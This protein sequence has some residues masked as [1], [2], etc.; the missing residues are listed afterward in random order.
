MRLRDVL[1]VFVKNPE[2]GQ[3]KTRLAKT[4]GHTNA[5]KIYRFLLEH[6][7]NVALE[8]P[9]ERLIVY[10]DYIDFE[11]L[12]EPREFIKD[13]QRGE[14][15]GV[16]MLNAFKD[17]FE[18]GYKK[19]VLIG[20]DCYE[21]TSDILVDAF[22]ALDKKDLV[23][24]PAKDGGYYLIG[25]KQPHPKLFQQ[26]SW[27]EENVFIDTLLDAKKL[28][29]SYFLLPTL[30]DV[31]EEEDLGPLKDLINRNSKTG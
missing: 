31:D 29:L 7:K 21:I 19:I 22:F 9:V 24:G 28:G 15:L 12:F 20:S 4:I 17:N 6:T 25:M 5:L 8:T 26:K 23:L 10:S 11:D 2:F 27:G 30:S 3:V 16:R 14:N 18:D 1:V 13:V